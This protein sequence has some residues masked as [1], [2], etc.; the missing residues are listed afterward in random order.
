MVKHNKRIRIITKFEKESRK[1]NILF[2]DKVDTLKDIYTANSTI[3]STKEELNAVYTT[4][5]Y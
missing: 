2:G 5:H 4:Q 3:I 1:L